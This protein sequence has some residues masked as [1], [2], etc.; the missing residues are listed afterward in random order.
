M[1]KFICFGCRSKVENDI[2]P[3]ILI[4]KESSNNIDPPEQCPFYNDSYVFWE[5]IDEEEY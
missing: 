2:D 4:M 5:I 3:C 1:T